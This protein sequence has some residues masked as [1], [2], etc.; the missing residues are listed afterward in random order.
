VLKPGIRPQGGPA[1]QASD[2]LTEVSC[3]LCP[4]GILEDYILSINTN[5]SFGATPVPGVSPVSPAAPATDPVGGSA[6]ALPAFSADHA[7]TNVAAFAG[8]A[9]LPAAP[10]ISGAPA[11][12]NMSGYVGL[13]PAR[14]LDP[15]KFIFSNVAASADG[16]FTVQVRQYPLPNGK[17][18]VFTNGVAISADGNAVTYDANSG[19]LT[20]N[21]KETAIVPGQSLS[22]PG[23]AKLYGTGGPEGAIH[24]ETPQGDQMTFRTAYAPVEGGMLGMTQKFARSGLKD[25]AGPATP[26]PELAGVN[27]GNRAT[28]PGTNPI[29]ISHDMSGITAIPPAPP[30]DESKAEY[31]TTA[32]SASGDLKVQ[33]RMYPSADGKGMITNGAG[34]GVDG[35]KITYDATSGVLT[36]DGKALTMKPGDVIKLKGGGE[37]SCGA[38]GK[39]HVTSAK[40]D[41][42]SMQTVFNDT[43]GHMIG[44]TDEISSTRPKGDVKGPYHSQS[45][46]DGSA[47][48]NG[49]DAFPSWRSTESEMVMSPGKGAVGGGA[50]EPVGGGGPDDG[51]SGA[52]SNGIADIMAMFDKLE[53]TDG[54]VKLAEVQAIMKKILELLAKR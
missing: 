4:P 19:R 40:G 9:T 10:A 43:N 25:A 26:S 34:I 51:L 1:P 3:N 32:Q 15:A 11:D 7:Q 35:Q 42:F 2:V 8:E 41:K 47:V 21:G 12:K 24:F 37:L 14:N 53:A 49:S 31:Y 38:D 45:N 5:P 13:P 39:Y 30:Y 36:L 18:G 6:P 54:M 48:A 20:V 27:H 17:A 33:V 44:M 50:A 52:P 46:R 23:G 16:N 22:L 29:K 28:T